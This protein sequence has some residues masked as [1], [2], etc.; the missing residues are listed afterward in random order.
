MTCP[1]RTGEGEAVQRVADVNVLNQLRTIYRD[2]DRCL[3]IR[4]PRGFSRASHELRDVLGRLR[5]H[6]DAVSITDIVSNARPR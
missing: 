1:S 5:K 4:D 2:I 3:D 6:I